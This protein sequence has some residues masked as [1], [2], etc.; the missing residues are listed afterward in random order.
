MEAFL[1]ERL[2]PE[3]ARILAGAFVR[4][5]YA[6]ELSDLGA[7]SAFPRLWKACEE[8]GGLVRGLLAAG[9]QRPPELPGPRTSRTALLSFPRGLREL[10]EALSKALGDR[11]RTRS[12]VE[13]LARGGAGWQVRLRD[14]TSTNGDHL[15]L[16]VP[17]PAAARLLAPF[18]RGRAPIE[19]LDG[20]R[21]ADVTVVHVGI[22]RSAVPSLPPGFGFLVPP[23]AAGAPRALGT[24]FTSNL[25]PGRAPDGCVA[26]SSFYAS[27]DVGNP[28]DREL[29]AIACEDLA[30]GLG[31]SRPP[32]PRAF[33]VRRWE[34]GIPRYAPGHAP[35]M[36]ALE[37]AT[38]RELPGLHLAGSYV[39]GVAVDQ[40]IARGRAVAAEILR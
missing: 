14:G 5:V 30:R 2:G 8:H 17:A 35:R 6:A 19:S 36:E 34:H 38:R 29:A 37:S 25:F 21:H 31:Q 39:A 10:V 27:A 1:T 18:A 32:E 26:V 4:G 13:S 9:K 33:D 40:V 24:I 20:V 22:A 3:A 28:G 7:R 16:A 12:E 23:G 11:L 15:V